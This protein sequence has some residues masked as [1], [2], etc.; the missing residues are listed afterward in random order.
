MEGVEGRLTRRSAE[1]GV[2]DRCHR[3][4]GVKSLTAGT[5]TLTA[6]PTKGH[7]TK[8]HTMSSRAS[9]RTM[10]SLATEGARR[11]ARKGVRVRLGA[12]AAEGEGEGEGV[13]LDGRHLP[14]PRSRR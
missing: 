12:G 5:P 8:G 6:T 4:H 11:E 1:A 14:L 2:G 10:I 9:H 13:G 7:T 3:V